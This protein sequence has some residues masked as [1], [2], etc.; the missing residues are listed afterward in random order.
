MEQVPPGGTHVA[1]TVRV[2]LLFDT[3]TQHALPAAVAQG[4]PLQSAAALDA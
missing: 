2:P 4:V 3:M 1:Y